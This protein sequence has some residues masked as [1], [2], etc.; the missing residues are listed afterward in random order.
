MARKP[1]APHKPWSG[2]PVNPLI[3]LPEPP[4]RKIPGG[5]RILWVDFTRC[6][7]GGTYAAFRSGATFADASLRLRQAAKAAGDDGG[8]FRSRRPVLT[9][10]RAIK[11]EA[12]FLEHWPCG[13]LGLELVE[14]PPAVR[15]CPELLAA[16]EA[17]WP[18]PPEL[19]PEDD[20]PPF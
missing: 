12:W 11:L 20:D 18:T 8:G 15:E 16:L 5:R 13:G 14:D 6:T 4:T 10:L 9:Q 17:D 1:R 2:V 3:M 7:C 19:V